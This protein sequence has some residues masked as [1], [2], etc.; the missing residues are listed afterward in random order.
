MSK[1]KNKKLKLDVGQ[2][3]LSFAS[4]STSRMYVVRQSDEAITKSTTSAT[5][6]GKQK[7][8][9]EKTAEKKVSHE[10]ILKW[11][12]IHNWLVYDRNK[13]AMFCIIC[14]KAGQGKT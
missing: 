8:C 10:T 14:Q 6:S 12:A 2:Q 7:E 4:V 5:D 1:H 3:K 11:K 9:K 13:N